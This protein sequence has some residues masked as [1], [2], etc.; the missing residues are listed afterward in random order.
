[1]C[2]NIST[3]IQF[4]LLLFLSRVPSLG[5]ESLTA[6]VMCRDHATE[7]IEMSRNIHVTGDSDR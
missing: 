7:R 4:I 6:L 5:G 2:L 3:R 1:M